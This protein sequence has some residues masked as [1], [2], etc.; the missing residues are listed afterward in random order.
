MVETGQGE[1]AGTGDAAQ[2]VTEREDGNGTAAFSVLDAN[3]KFKKIAG[4]EC[5]AK[6]NQRA[7]GKADVHEAD[8]QAAKPDEVLDRAGLHHGRKD[9]VAGLIKDAAG[10]LRQHHGNRV[11]GDGFGAKYPHADDRCRIVGHG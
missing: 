5:Q 2:Q 10:I 6:K 11:N 9:G 3:P 4:K 8:V 1:R 7:D